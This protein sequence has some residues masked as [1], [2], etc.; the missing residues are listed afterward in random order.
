[1]MTA[2]RAT[3]A[4]T[5]VLIVPRRAPAAMLADCPESFTCSKNARCLPGDCYFN[6]CVAGFRCE[7]STGSWQCLPGS[8]GAGGA[9]ENEMTQAGAGGGTD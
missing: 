2:V 8:A 7:S 3:A 1:M 5:R 9:G 4:T 6:D